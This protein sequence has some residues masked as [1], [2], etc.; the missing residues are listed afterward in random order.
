MPGGVCLTELA[1]R[2]STMRST[3]GAST[4]R[5]QAPS[6]LSVVTDIRVPGAPYARRARPR[7]RPERAA[8]AARGR[9]RSRSSRSA[10]S[11]S[12]RRRLRSTGGRRSSAVRPGRQ[13]V[14]ALLQRER[15]AEDRRQRRAQLV[16]DRREDRVAQLV[17]LAA[18][19][20]VLRRADHAH[21]ARPSAPS[22]TRPRPCSQRTGAA[23]RARRGGRTRTRRLPRTRARRGRARRPRRRDGVAPGTPRRS[24][25]C[26]GSTPN[27]RYSS[28][29]HVIRSSGMLHSQL[30]MCATPCAS[31]SASSGRDEP[32][33]RRLALGQH[34]AEEQ[35]RDGDRGEE[36]L[37]DLDGLRRRSPGRAGRSPCT[38][39]ATAI[40]DAPRSSPPPR[41]AGGSAARP[42][43]AAGRASSVAPRAAEEDRRGGRRERREQH[44]PLDLARPR[45]SRGGARGP[46]EEQRR[47]DELAHGVADPP[48]QPRRPVVTPLEVVRE[49]ERGDAV[50]RRDR[51]RRRGAEERRAR[52]RPA[53][54]RARAGSSRGAA[55]SRRRA[56]RACS[57]SRSRRR[58]GSTRRS[59]RSRAARRRR[60]RARCAGRTGRR[61]RARCPPAPRRA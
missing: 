58:P 29:D 3:F 55:A 6:G 53:C 26:P 2:F 45:E 12:R 28:S 16:R 57:P 13:P 42:R 35:Q 48:E 11:R 54:A 7:R 49:P 32:L 46:D 24:S 47:D 34:G 15:E 61:R 43:R 60:S 51:G 38:A 41:P 31:A 36:P 14:A 19:G 4:S 27:S 21:A 56:P 18:L 40:A 33:L 22:T 20:D 52:R 50:R 8:R 37:H 30:P 23:S 59:S 39:P 10:S 1:S 17:E 44:D 25:H 5:R 9:R